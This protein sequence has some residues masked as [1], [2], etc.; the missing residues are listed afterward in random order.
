MDGW[1]RE[2]TPALERLTRGERPTPEGIDWSNVDAWNANGTSVP[3]GR[4]LFA[5]ELIHQCP[6]LPVE[7][8]DR[9]RDPECRDRFLERVFE[10][11][12]TRCGK[13]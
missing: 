7:E 12:R 11:A 5:S 13:A 1:L 9:L 8:E 6:T 3:A 2:M 10:Y 4:G